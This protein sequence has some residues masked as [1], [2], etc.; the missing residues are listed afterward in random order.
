[1][2]EYYIITGGRRQDCASLPAACHG[3]QTRSGS[4]TLPL[5]SHTAPGAFAAVTRGG[6]VVV[7]QVSEDAPR[8]HYE[9]TRVQE[10]ATGYA[11]LTVAPYCEGQSCM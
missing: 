8:G 6:P 1:M 7:P 9:A 10:L 3:L 2:V 11:F 4:A 5:T